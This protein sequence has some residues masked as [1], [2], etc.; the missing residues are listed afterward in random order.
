MDLQPFVG[1]LPLS[2]FLNH[3]HSRAG[4]LDRGSAPRKAATCTQDNTDTE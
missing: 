4:S 1:P 3:I 2:K